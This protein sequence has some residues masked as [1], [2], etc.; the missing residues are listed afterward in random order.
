ML[1]VLR[2]HWAA[3]SYPWAH[4]L[5]RRPSQR[6]RIS[7]GVRVHLEHHCSPC[8]PKSR[9]S[10]ASYTQ[11]RTRSADVMWER[12]PGI[13]FT[14]GPTQEHQEKQEK[15]PTPLGILNIKFRTYSCKTCHFL[16]Q[17]AMSLEYLKGSN[18]SQIFN[19]PEEKHKQRWTQG[20][21]RT[22]SP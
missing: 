22:Q 21:P 17:L 11:V 3:V 2:P 1:L 5:T 16:K 15:R 8:L 14:K 7:P 9:S 20:N 12:A 4:P 18:A 6:A 13:P 19:S 10:S